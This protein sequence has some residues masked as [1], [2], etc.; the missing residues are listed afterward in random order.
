[1][2]ELLEQ[3]L[4]GKYFQ[5]NYYEGEIIQF[6]KISLEA[7]TTEDIIS[8][9]NILEKKHKRISLKE[10]QNYKLISEKDFKKVEKKYHSRS[11]SLLRVPCTDQTSGF[12][13]RIR[14]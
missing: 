1:M 14:E 11:L 6:Q 3:S 4:K 13:F 8:V 7:K 12:G 10:L 5:H 2:Y 9:E